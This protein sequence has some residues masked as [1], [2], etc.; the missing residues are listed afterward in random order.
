MVAYATCL[1]R[2]AF[3]NIDAFDK[4]AFSMNKIYKKLGDTVLLTGITAEE[5]GALCICISKIERLDNPDYVCGFFDARPQVVKEHIQLF[6]GDK[7]K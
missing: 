2:M 3:W 1:S 7:D 4:V 5:L 6:K